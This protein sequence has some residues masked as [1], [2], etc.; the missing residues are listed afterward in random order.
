MVCPK[1]GGEN[2]AVNVVNDVKLKD[3]HHNVFWWIFVGFW[4]IP[5]KWLFFTLPALIFKIFG[6]KKQ[7]AINKQKKVCCCQS[8]GYT[9]DL[10]K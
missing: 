3:K 8:C 2:V 10:K 4:W 7:K 6:R 5:I 1:C 9:W